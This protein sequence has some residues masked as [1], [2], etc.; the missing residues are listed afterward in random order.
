M[1]F[2]NRNK[3][4]FLYYISFAVIA[5]GAVIGSLYYTLNFFGDRESALHI[6]DYIN[7]LKSGMDIKPIIKSSIRTY[8]ILFLVIY[9]SSYFKRGYIMSF[10]WLGRKGFINAFTLS[11][12]LDVFGVNGVFL[13]LSNIPQALILLPVSA[14]FSSSAYLYSKNKSEF[15]KKEKIIYIIFSIVVFTTFCVCALTEGIITTTFMK[16]VANKVT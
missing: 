7:S 9:I 13:L 6:N 5:A 12:I 2:A 15:N 10:F 8:S 4:I 3:F 1:H 14:L 16:W 11:A